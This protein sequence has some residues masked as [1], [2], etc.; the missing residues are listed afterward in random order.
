MFIKAP[1]H[2]KK[3]EASY[4]SN[5]NGS[6][7]LYINIGKIIVIKKYTVRAH[8]MLEKDVHHTLLNEHTLNKYRW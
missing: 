4:H 7:V 1:F 2:N 3:L 8:W 5:K 6:L